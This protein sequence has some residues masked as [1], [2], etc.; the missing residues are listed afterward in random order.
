MGRHGNSGS[1]G[2]SWSD[3]RF[4]TGRSG[5]Q[6]SRGQ[7][8]ENGSDVNVILQDATDFVRVFISSD[9]ETK[10]FLLA[11]SSE[12]VFVSA[13]G[14]NGGDGGNGSW[15]SVDKDISPQSG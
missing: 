8:G 5:S 15:W 2:E 4:Y 1:A 10:D 14:G 12:P 7:D 11:K 9:T 6:G 3:G 13:N